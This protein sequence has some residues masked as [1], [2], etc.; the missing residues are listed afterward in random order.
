M[1]TTING[2]GI[3]FPNGTTQT[4]AASGAGTVTSVA[5]GGGLTGGT[6]TTS[7]TISLDVYNSGSTTSSLPLGSYVTARNPSAGSGTPGFY[8][9]HTVSTNAAYEDAI[10]DGNPSRTYLSGTWRSRGRSGETGD[11]SYYWITFQRTA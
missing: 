8:S 6:I 2:T 10:F 4:T 5:T 1:P 7:G 9:S 3:T 11:G